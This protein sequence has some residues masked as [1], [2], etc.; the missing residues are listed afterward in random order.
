VSSTYFR[1][2]ANGWLRPLANTL[3]CRVEDVLAAH[4]PFD[5]F[6]AKFVIRAQHDIG[7]VDGVLELLGRA[8]G[9]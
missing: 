2:S 6:D 5:M 9:R 4:T 7:R 8:G 3:F 1:S